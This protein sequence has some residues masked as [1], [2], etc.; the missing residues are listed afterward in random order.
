MRKN[1]FGRQFKRDKN[2]RK[3]LFKGLLNALILNERIKTTEEKAKSIKGDADKLITTAK[4]NSERAYKLLEPR[5]AHDANKKVIEDIA[6]RFS[7][8]PGGYTRITKI[9]RRTK[10]NASM[11][12]IEWTELGTKNMIKPEDVQIIEPTATVENT[13]EIAQPKKKEAKSKTTK[14]STTK[15]TKTKKE[16]EAK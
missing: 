13:A 11:V 15:K 10:D 6:P 14:S 4:R 2:Q 9:G 16:E 12:M 7:Q 8:R 5:I 1:V 3:A